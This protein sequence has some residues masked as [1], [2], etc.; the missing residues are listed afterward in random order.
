MVSNMRTP[1]ENVATR[2][3]R[4]F[5][6][7]RIHIYY[8]YFE[9]QFKSILTYKFS[10]ISTSTLDVVTP[11]FF[12]ML[13]SAVASLSKD[14]KIGD[15]DQNGIIGY[16]LIGILLQRLGSTY[17]SKH[18]IKLIKNKYEQNASFFLL[19]SLNIALS[20]TLSFLSKIIATLIF[21]S[22]IIISVFILFPPIRLSVN[23][24]LI[25]VISFLLFIIIGFCINA[26]FNTL[27]G[28]LRFYSV[29]A[30]SFRSITFNFI[31]FLSG[32]FIPLS[33]L[34]Q[35]FKN[36]ISFLPFAYTYYFPLSIILGKKS[37]NEILIGFVISITWILLLLCMATYMYKRGIKYFENFD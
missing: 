12:I 33:F 15:F 28:L 29:S 9:L 7:H 1:H 8:K 34:S 25:N 35:G 3:Q 23:L 4:V 20:I 13:W 2:I 26:L 11:L 16:Y 19:N 32:Q 21:T 18:L 5:F 10:F 14:K 24:S 37:P 22:I 30:S 27:M 36:A 6:F 31:T 17:I